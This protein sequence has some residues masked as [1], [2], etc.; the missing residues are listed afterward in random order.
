MES[1]L[2]RFCTPPAASETESDLKA[3]EGTTEG[4]VAFEGRTLVTYTWAG[5]RSV[6]LAHG[7][8]S[9]A[10]H[11]ALLGRG[12]ARKGYRVVTFDA[13]AHGRSRRGGGSPLSNGFEFGRAIHAVAE[14]AGPFSAV[15]GHSV[16][17]AAAVYTVSGRGVMSPSR[18][19]VEE[20]V[21]I[22]TPGGINQLME[23]W[24]A[25]NGGGFAELKRAL[26]REFSCS[27]DDYEVRE[28]LAQVGCPILM[29]HDEN[30]E[31]APA[32]TAIEAARDVP[33]I[34]LTLTS[35]LGHSRILAGRETL[36]AI[37][38]FLDTGAALT[39]G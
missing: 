16:A 37:L 8:G 27:T 26:D 36:R 20:L 39:G 19:A 7:W 10:S 5:R 32:R 21:L 1:I 24:C 29:V 35:G 34:R 9:R 18:F 3:L 23:S 28:A 33:G 22:S 30:D 31:E 4:T 11:M 38:S 15:I 17:A 25:R 13:P 6:L 14:A 2:E 12:L